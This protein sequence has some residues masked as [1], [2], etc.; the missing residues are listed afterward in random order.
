MSVAS[1]KQSI[2]FVVSIASVVS[3]NKNG[4]IDTIDSMDTMDTID[5]DIP[6]PKKKIVLTKSEIAP[7]AL[8]VTGGKM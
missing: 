5:S 1:K 4:Q 2:E 6:T 3:K 7:L 8:A